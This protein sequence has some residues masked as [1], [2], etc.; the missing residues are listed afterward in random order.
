VFYSTGD[1]VSALV[2]QLWAVAEVRLADVAQIL[3]QQLP[4]DPTV[5]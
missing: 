2:H 5:T 3:R 1:D 4:A